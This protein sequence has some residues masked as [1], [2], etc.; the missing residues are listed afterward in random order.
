MNKR[1]EIGIVL[2]SIVRIDAIGCF[3]STRLRSIHWIIGANLS[4]LKEER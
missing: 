3:H 2:Y 1:I 4:K